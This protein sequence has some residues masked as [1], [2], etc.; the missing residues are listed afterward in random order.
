MNKI[1]KSTQLLKK[2]PKCIFYTKRVNLTENGTFH[3]RKKTQK[4][5]KKKHPPPKKICKIKKFLFNPYKN[6]SLLYFTIVQ[7]AWYN[8][9]TLIYYG[10]N[11]KTSIYHGKNMLLC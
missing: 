8:I 11:N 6:Y 2:P 4:T 7:T 5:N 1:T 3:T 10:E 9:K